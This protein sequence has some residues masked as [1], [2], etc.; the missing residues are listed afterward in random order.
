ML[1]P[2]QISSWVWSKTNLLDLNHKK[3]R[4][5]TLG[6]LSPCSVSPVQPR[7]FYS[8]RCVVSTLGSENKQ[9]ILFHC[10]LFI[11]AVVE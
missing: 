2:C 3:N 10:V 9:G 1:L 7:S 5:S 6:A 11:P 8:A 4:I